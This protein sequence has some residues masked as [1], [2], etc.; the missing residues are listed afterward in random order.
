MKVAAA[1]TTFTL[2]ITASAGLIVYAAQ[3]RIEAAPSA[4]VIVGGL[5]GGLMG[6]RIQQVMAPQRVRRVL[7]VLL[8]L[9]GV[10]LLVRG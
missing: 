7:S 5:A 3:G 10:V 1:T 2:G 6:A 9:I 4:A 8:I